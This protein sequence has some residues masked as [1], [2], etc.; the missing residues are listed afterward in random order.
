MGILD[1]RACQDL[2]PF[3]CD[4]QLIEDSPQQAAGNA[5]AVAVQIYM[6]CSP[7]LS[8]T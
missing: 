2:T 5:L 4:Q 3:N 7:P 8:I 6:L 1:F